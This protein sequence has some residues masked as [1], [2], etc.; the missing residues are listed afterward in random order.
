M[1]A[2]CQ[3]IKQLGVHLT[4]PLYLLQQREFASRLKNCC[5]SQILSSAIDNRQLEVL[6]DY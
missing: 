1:G 3:A 2:L 5:F 6:L 4:I